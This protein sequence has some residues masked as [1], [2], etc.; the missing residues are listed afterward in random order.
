V[1]I[2]TQLPSEFD[3]PFNF[4]DGKVFPQFDYIYGA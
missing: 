3:L 4:N 1:F 2:L